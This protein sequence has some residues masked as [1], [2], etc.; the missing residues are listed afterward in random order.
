MDDKLLV[1]ER[2]R[3]EKKLNFLFK[4]IESIK[5]WGFGYFKIMKKIGDPP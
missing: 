3:I 5:D 4:G 2:L 1:K